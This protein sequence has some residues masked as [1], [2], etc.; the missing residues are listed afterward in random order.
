MVQL[1]N[2]HILSYIIYLLYHDIL[3]KLS[4]VFLF[5]SVLWC[6]I[7]GH[8]VFIY[9]VLWFWSDVPVSKKGPSYLGWYPGGES[10]VN[11]G[12]YPGKK[13]EFCMFVL[14]ILIKKHNVCQNYSLHVKSLVLN[15]EKMGFVLYN[16][17]IRS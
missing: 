6:L 3:G 14:K 15:M 16:L 11:Y 10:I 9:L 2:L 7:F 4:S 1:T 8:M 12:V 17:F 13:T 5:C